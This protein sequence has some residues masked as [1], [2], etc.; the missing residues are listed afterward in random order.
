MGGFSRPAPPA[1]GRKEQKEF[2]DLVK[3]YVAPASMPEHKEAVMSEAEEDEAVM[4]PQ[5]RQKPKAKFEGETNP[6]TGEVGGPKHEPLAHGKSFSFI[7]PPLT[8][9]FMRYQT[10]VLNRV[11]RKVE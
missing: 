5:F 1:L 3:S 4:H 11:E 7:D 2:E 6:E 10:I 9:P 8:M